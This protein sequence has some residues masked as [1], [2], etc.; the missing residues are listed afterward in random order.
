MQ[1]QIITDLEK[2]SQIRIG[3]I[4]EDLGSM[5]FLSFTINTRWLPML[6]PKESSSASSIFLDVTNMPEM[7]VKLHLV[8]NRGTFN[9]ENISKLLSQEVLSVLSPHQVN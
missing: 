1:A 7:N 5:Q 6:I 3:K 2:R 9:H 8:C 4:L